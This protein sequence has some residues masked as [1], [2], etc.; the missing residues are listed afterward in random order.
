MDT[1]I[2][3]MLIDDEILAI[4]HMQGMLDWEKYGFT[5]VCYATQPQKALK[6]IEEHQPQVL[7]VDIKMPVMDGIQFSSAVL[8]RGYKGLILLLTSVKQFDYAQEALR[9]GIHNYL[10]KHELGSWRH[11]CLTGILL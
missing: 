10:V 5:V 1:Y 7:F 6:M 9:M 2:K 4:R 11:C 3:V 8:A